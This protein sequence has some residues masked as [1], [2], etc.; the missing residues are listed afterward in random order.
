MQDDETNSGTIVQDGK[1]NTANDM[2]SLILGFNILLA[3]AI[4]M[5]MLIVDR[6]E[7]YTGRDSKC[8]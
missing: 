2:L 3:I 4:Y 1:R 8:F 5:A 7:K 6:V